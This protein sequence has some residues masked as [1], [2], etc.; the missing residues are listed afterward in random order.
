M[1]RLEVEYDRQ[2]AYFTP[3]HSQPAISNLN[4]FFLGTDRQSNYERRG[5]KAS[6]RFRIPDWDMTLGYRNAKDQPMPKTTSFTLFGSDSSVPGV[7]LADP[8]EYD[9]LFGRVR[10]ARQDW[11]FAGLVEGKGLGD[12]T[13]RLRSAVAKDFRLGRPIRGFV[14]VEG[15]AAEA[16]APIQR[17]FQQGGPVA[18]PTLGFG[19]GDT[20]HVLL[21]RL[22]LVEGHNLLRLLKVPHP[23]FMD[24]NGGVFFHYGA[25][26]DDP[27]RRDIL[28]SKPPGDAWRGAAGMMLVYRPGLPNPRTLWRIQMGWPVGPEGGV[29]RLTLSVGSEFDLVLD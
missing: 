16:N 17:R 15:G 24:F 26:W 6:V 14:Q 8:I 3:E 10:F 13:W 4:A 18:I 5:I 20:D 12:A 22:E 7:T 19:V 9:E 28:F 2:T 25:V 23:D 1:L 11:G 29:A 21:G 27:A